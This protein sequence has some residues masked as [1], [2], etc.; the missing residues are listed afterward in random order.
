MIPIH[1]SYKTAL[2]N[3]VPVRGPRSGF[4]GSGVAKTLF[5]RKEISPTGEDVTFTLPDAML[6]RFDSMAAKANLSSDLTKS[7]SIYSRVLFARIPG[8]MDALAEVIS[9]IGPELSIKDV[10][11]TPSSYSDIAGLAVYRWLKN[12]RLNRS[13]YNDITIAAVLARENIS[14]APKGSPESLFIMGTGYMP[15]ID[16]TR[17]LGGFAPAV[18]FGQRHPAMWQDLF[19]WIGSD[20]EITQTVHSN[21][22]Y[23][24]GRWPWWLQVLCMS[25]NLVRAYSRYAWLRSPMIVPADPS[26]IESFYPYYLFGQPGLWKRSVSR[27]RRLSYFN[28]PQKKFDTAGISCNIADLVAFGTGR[29]AKIDPLFEDPILKT[30]DRLWLHAIAGIST[31]SLSATTT[32]QIVGLSEYPVKLKVELVPALRQL[33]RSEAAPNFRLGGVRS[34]SAAINSV[35]KSIKF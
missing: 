19:S 5:Y 33:I 35:L 16:R 2:P 31:A 30:D 24:L 29:D 18:G 28:A 15:D 26:A 14:F 9:V 7:A 4:Y 17:G 32:G 6:G 12:N 20:A 8:L 10:A 34:A 22:Y 25:G 1:S 23:A 11:M 27:L 21:A 3:L 13:M